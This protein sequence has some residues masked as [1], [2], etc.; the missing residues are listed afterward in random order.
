MA[1]LRREAELGGR[2]AHPNVC[3][4]IRL[5][6]TADGRVYIVMPFVQG[7]LLCDHES[8]VGQLAL[9]RTRSADRAH[10]RRT[11]AWRT[12]SAS[13]TAISSRRTSCSAR[14]PTGRSAR[15]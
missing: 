15:W 3:H 8:R 6:E 11:A 9:D 10:R 14:H 7:E 5:G 2:L 4:I 1:R 13:S 12:S